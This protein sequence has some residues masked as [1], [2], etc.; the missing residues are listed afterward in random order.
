MDGGRLIVSHCQRSLP[1]CA[2]RVFSVTRSLSQHHRCIH[3]RFSNALDTRSKRVIGI[4]VF[5][6]AICI[7]AD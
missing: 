7:E 6:L 4:S 1:N 5:V 2:A 3:H